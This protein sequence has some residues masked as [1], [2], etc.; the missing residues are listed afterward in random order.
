[1]FALASTIAVLVATRD[2]ILRGTD[3]EVYLAA[4]DSVWDGRGLTVPFTSFTDRYSPRDAEAFDGRVP[5]S[6]FGPAYPLAIS[7]VRLTGLDGPDAARVLHAALVALSVVLFA[8]LVRRLTP[9]APWWVIGAGIVVLLV[10]PRGANLLFHHLFVASEPLFVASTL[11]A[12]LLVDRALARDATRDWVLAGLVVG[13]ALA[14]RFAGVGLAIGVVAVAGYRTRIRRAVLVGA[15]A[16]TPTLVFVAW[17]AAAGAAGRPIGWHVPERLGHFLFETLSEWFSPRGASWLAVIVLAG[18]TALVASVALRQHMPAMW[19]VCGVAVAAYLA[20]VLAAGILF[21][22]S[23]P[24]AGR[25]LSPLLPVAVAMIVAAAAR[26]GRAAPLAI[27]ACVV[28]LAVPGLRYTWRLEREGVPENPPP[29]A[30]PLLDGVPAGVAVFTNDPLGVYYDTGRSSL[31]V[32]R[33]DDVFV[34]GGNPRFDEYVA[35]LRQLVCAGD[36]VVLMRG[37]S[38]PGVAREADLGLATI[39][40]S[41][42]DVLLGCPRLSGAAT[43]GRA[44][45]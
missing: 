22:R 35:Q 37:P 29:R 10:G 9:A 32:P 18:A 28:L 21:D 38:L 2:G 25:L 33:R 1:M 45:R 3:S 15:I 34:G 40:T 5:L 44:R 31:L 19:A 39:T 16:A 6:Q 14:S 7:L 12:L 30:I 41:G 13:A 11:G 42:T 43:R 27:G 20:G 8:V 17:N 26:I 23:L 24:V 4:S 36:A